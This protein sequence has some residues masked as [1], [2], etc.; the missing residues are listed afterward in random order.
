MN[1]TS[2]SS[3][4]GKPSQKKM[5]TRLA[6]DATQIG[7]IGVVHSIASA[8][9]GKDAIQSQ[10]VMRSAFKKIEDMALAMKAKKKA[11]TTFTDEE[12]GVLKALGGIIKDGV[13]SVVKSIAKNLFRAF[14]YAA[15]AVIVPV[16][17]IFCTAITSVFR[18]ILMNPYTLVATAVIAAAVAGRM[19]YLKR[20]SDLRSDKKSDRDV[21]TDNSPPRPPSSGSEVQAGK[22]LSTIDKAT[23]DG[24]KYSGKPSSDKVQD[25]IRE[26]AYRNKVPADL[27]LK[28]AGAESTYKT[29]AVNKTGS[30]A[31]GLFQFVDS[32]WKEM[33]GKPGEQM[34]PVKNADLGTKYIRKNYETLRKVLGRD[35]GY[36]E[37]YASHFFGPS[38]AKMFKSGISLDAPIEKGL[39]TFHSPKGVRLVMQQNPNLRGKTIRSVLAS[40]KD[41]V[42]DRAAGAA[43]AQADEGPAPVATAAASPSTASSN[44]LPSAAG[45]A[46]GSFVIPTTGTYVSAFGR[47]ASPLAGASTNHQ[48]ID[49]AGPLGTA[50]YAADG[51]VVVT[52]S[53]TSI[54]YGTRIDIDHGN[55]FITRYG[56]SRKLYVGVG[57]KVKKGQHIADMGSQGISQG[58]HLHFEV[59]TVTAGT[60][61]GFAT[62]SNPVDP[63]RYLYGFPQAKGG[64]VSNQMVAQSA[65]SENQYAMVGNKIVTFKG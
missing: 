42:G 52:S 2:N 41:K 40:L 9:Q 64:S 39:A 50:I 63:A 16:F 3:I 34:D 5:A 22:D 31:K 54:G 27:A 53:T 61:V 57:D 13:V 30:S 4:L 14:M 24:T 11:N 38:V 60:K 10:K 15:R 56:H 25:I 48:G 8:I 6:I 17:S 51:G 55:G 35:V 36:H 58:S 43:F 28:M 45:L 23:K 33:G 44:G 18:L 1:I 65:R 7:S 59:R 37:V 32:T 62:Q 49:I 47:R 29:D 12:S 21:Y 19:W 20:E 26:A 46:T